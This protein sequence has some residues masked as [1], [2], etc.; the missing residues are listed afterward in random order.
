MQTRRIHSMMIALVAMLVAGCPG[1]PEQ[2]DRE[3]LT[4]A[5]QVIEK[6]PRNDGH[7]PLSRRAPAFDVQ[8]EL[9]GKVR[10][11]RTGFSTTEGDFCQLF[12][13]LEDGF[14]VADNETWSGHDCPWPRH[15]RHLPLDRKAVRAIGDA[16]HDSASALEVHQPPN[17]RQDLLS[18]ATLTTDTE[19]YDL[20][21]SIQEAMIAETDRLLAIWLNRDLDPPAPT[22]WTVASIAGHYVRAS[23]EPQGIMV[24]TITTSSGAQNRLWVL[25]R[26]D[27][28][29]IHELIRE[30]PA[31]DWDESAPSDRNVYM[32]APDGEE[33][34]KYWPESAPARIH[35]LL[36]LTALREHETKD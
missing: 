8:N 23:I 24:M 18:E 28:R 26:D 29:E 12:I 20:D 27:I 22:I 2:P 36:E 6:K 25:D 1:A 19:E 9:L 17:T 31:A 10:Y 4:T 33:L 35:R 21:E 34:R 14:L 32:V 13:S 3:P 15:G 30:L 11:M 7:I 5:L 16:I